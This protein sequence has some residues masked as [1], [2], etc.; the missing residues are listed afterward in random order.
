MAWLYVWLGITAVA[1][2]IEFITSEMVS[3]WFA[4][5]GLIA[6]IIS[7]FGVE[8]YVHVPVFIALSLTLLLSFR[9]MALKYLDKGDIRTNADSAIGKEFTLL[10]PISFNQAGT[11][12]IND[13]IWSV[14]TENA[15]ESLSEGTIVRVKSLK[16]NKYIVE[17][18]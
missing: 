10:S 11:I 16:G 1:L 3:I 2:V 13:V 5:G 8:W 14:I 12:K 9:K 15:N 4:G 6:M 17:K 7:A 18:V